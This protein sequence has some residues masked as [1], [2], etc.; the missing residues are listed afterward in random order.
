MR[1]KLIQKISKNLITIY[2]GLKE[3]IQGPRKIRDSNGNL[4]KF[5]NYKIN[6]SS[7]THQIL[8]C[9]VAYILH[10]DSIGYLSK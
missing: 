7:N 1:F 4:T 5:G 2:H 8:F 6:Q 3:N 10:Y 9:N